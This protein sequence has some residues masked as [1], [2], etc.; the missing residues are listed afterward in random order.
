MKELATIGSIVIHEQKIAE[1]IRVI[2]GNRRRNKRLGI[3][4]Y[5]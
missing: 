2:L 3:V 1:I 4:D 5:E